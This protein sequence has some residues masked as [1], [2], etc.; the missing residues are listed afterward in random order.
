MSHFITRLLKSNCAVVPAYSICQ[1]YLFSGVF[2]PENK[3]GGTQH[4]YPTRVRQPA[5][6]SWPPPSVPRPAV[7]AAERRRRAA[8]L[9]TSGAAESGRTGIAVCPPPRGAQP[10]RSQVSPP[11]RRLVR[12]GVTAGRS[13]RR[14]ASTL[15]IKQHRGLPAG[16]DGL[17]RGAAAA[18]LSPP[19]VTAGAGLLRRPRI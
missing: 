11:L 18:S 10:L 7:P 6:L 17:P 19:P 13:S 16:T 9:P 14:G 5:G 1:Y 12:R 3:R 15:S 4:S 2:S 8:P